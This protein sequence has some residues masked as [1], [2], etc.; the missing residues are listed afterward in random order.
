MT[1]PSDSNS[2]D[3]T[4]PCKQHH[5]CPHCHEKLPVHTVKKDGPNKGRPFIS[6]WDCETLYWMDVGECK[7]CGAPMR[8]N[9][10]RKEGK[11]YGRKFKC[12]PNDCQGSFRWVS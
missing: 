8:E 12:C 5:K 10:V 4:N 2:T 7:Q 9:V 6:C 1:S 11:N 3:K